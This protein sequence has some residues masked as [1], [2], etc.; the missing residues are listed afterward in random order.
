MTRLADLTRIPPAAVLALTCLL[1]WA[2]KAHCGAAWSGDVQYTTGCYSDT[3]PFWGLRGV[4]AGQLPYLESRLE[5]PVLTG[6]LIWVEGLVTRTVWGAQATAAHFLFVVS[7]VNATLAFAVLGMMVRAGVP[8]ARRL[9]W[10]AA[11]PLVL[12]LGHNWDMLAA[13]FAVAALLAAA[14]A[15]PVR[16]TALAALGAAAK[17]FPVLLL[18]L[19]GIG[20][21]SSPG[22]AAQRVRRAAVLVL[23]AVLWWGAVNAPVAWTA[24]ANWSEFYRFSSAR[25]GTAASVWELLAQDGVWRSG[26]PARNLASGAL[27]VAGAGAIVALGWRRHGARPW[28]LFTPVLAW[29]LLTNKVY[30]PQFDLWLYPLLVLTSYRLWPLAWFAVGDLA[31]Y[32]AEFWWFAGLDGYHPAAS[33]IDIAFAAA[34][35]AGAM[36]W[37]IASAVRQPAPEWVQLAA[38]QDVTAP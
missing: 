26:T 27:F 31:A 7:A 34:L 14:A 18:P 10:A 29:F 20:A 6:A 8:R 23:V 1:G 35:R 22:D 16:A 37:V 13:T 33:Q 15:R 25:G 11:P 32:F 19:L 2:F 30:S 24:Y 5:Y 12:Y 17:L 9:C 28:L 4:A 36:L 38:R 3:V 21:L